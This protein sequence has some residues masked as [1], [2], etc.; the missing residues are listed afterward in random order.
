MPTPDFEIM[1]VSLQDASS[2]D[3][4]SCSARTGQLGQVWVFVRRKDLKIPVFRF[5]LKR[6]IR[7]DGCWSFGRN[8]GFE[9]TDVEALARRKDL[10]DFWL[11]ARR[12]INA[13][14]NLMPCM[15]KDSLGAAKFCVNHFFCPSDKDT[16]QD[17][18]LEWG[19]A[20]LWWIRA[21]RLY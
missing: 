5:Y 3:C 10:K 2:I 9:E 1:K 6:R 20:S 21:Y 17:R 14:M 16:F 8:E 19:S 18:I 7:K 12:I 15:T 13:R 11:A 4:F